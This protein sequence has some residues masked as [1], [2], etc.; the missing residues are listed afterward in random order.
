MRPYN[1]WILQLHVGDV[2]RL[3]PPSHPLRR[4]SQSGGKAL[5]KAEHLSGILQVS[6]A[7]FIVV[8]GQY[9]MQRGTG[10]VRRGGR[11]HEVPVDDSLTA[12]LEQWA[13]MI[14]VPMDIE[15]VD[16]GDSSSSS[17]AAGKL[18][19]AQLARRL[20]RYSGV[21]DMPSC[22]EAVRT[23]AAGVRGWLRVKGRQEALGRARTADAV[24]ALSPDH[25]QVLLDLQSMEARETS[26]VISM[27][28]DQS[29][30]FLLRPDP[31]GLNS[32]RSQ[33][34]P[35]SFL[36]LHFQPALPPLPFDAELM[37]LHARLEHAR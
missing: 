36:L 10:Q 29:P 2:A 21:R 31:H 5:V 27:G 34:A 37:R 22:I 19:E 35:P 7:D 16:A 12:F 9:N 8:V 4:T 20:E 1:C 32:I 15:G 25:Q 14:G 11:L 17:S 26:I 33:S 6:P 24:A 23:Q 3:V 13:S 28:S 30:F 18:S